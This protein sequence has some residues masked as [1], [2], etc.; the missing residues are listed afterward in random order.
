MSRTGLSRTGLS[1]TRVSRTG[2]SRTGLPRA[3]LPRA[4]LSRTRLPR[5]VLAVPVL[6]V[7]VLA[8]RVLARAV[9]AAARLPRPGLALPGSASPGLASPG[10]TLSRPRPV[11]PGTWL[12]WP[13]VTGTVLTRPG[14]T[15]T[16][17]AGAWLPGTVLPG[18]GATRT[19]L[20]GARLPGT[21]LPGDGAVLTRPGRPGAR[22]PRR[23]LAISRIGLAVSLC[24]RPAWL[25]ARSV[26]SRSRSVRVPVRGLGIPALIG[27]PAR[28]VRTR[29]RALPARPVLP[30]ARL[31]GSPFPWSVRSR[32]RLAGAVPTRS[33]PPRP[34][35][36]RPVLRSARTVR[37][38]RARPVRPVT[39]HRTSGPPGA[40]AGS[41]ASLR[42]FVAPVWARLARGSRSAAWS[43]PRAVRAEG[44]L[45]PGRA[46]AVRALGPG[47]A[48][49]RARPGMA[50]AR[51]GILGPLPLAVEYVLVA[52]SLPGWP[53]RETWTRRRRPF[54]AGARRPGRHVRWAGAAAGVSAVAG[55][56]GVGASV[57]VH[58]LGVAAIRVPGVRD[59][60]LRAPAGS[61]LPTFHPVPPGHCMF[62]ARRGR[63]PRMTSTACPASRTGMRY[64]PPALS[65]GR[66]ARG[67]GPDE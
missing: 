51:H 9:L 25:T 14:A 36:S 35:L 34:G 11:G 21:V 17:L 26:L 44:V 30:W 16:V 63:P 37:A 42:R 13:V 65:V 20:A 27:L 62:G 31:P 33:A 15:R 7:R 64:S 56:D 23:A 4:V 5:P 61:A 58:V 53:R 49:G 66:P 6:T 40:S 12:A 54:R 46:A 3:V 67:T 52:W 39:G 59:A 45:G 43:A 41:L 60:A 2:L 55:V 8:V 57:Q 47:P 19:V 18:A 10:L 29:P 38:G 48:A 22:P 1:R 24:S 28:A 50:D 32:P